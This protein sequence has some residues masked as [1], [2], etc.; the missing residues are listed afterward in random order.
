M[1]FLG[2]VPQ[3][4]GYATD[5]RSWML[6]DAITPIEEVRHQVF[7]YLDLVENAVGKRRKTIHRN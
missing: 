3:R 7:Y 2:R 1:M 4:L 5:G 6:T